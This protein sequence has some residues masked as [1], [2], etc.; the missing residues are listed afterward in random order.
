MFFGQILHSLP[1]KFSATMTSRQ[2]ILSTSTYYK[3]ASVHAALD[4][5][6][7]TFLPLYQ[8]MPTT[9]FSLPFNLLSFT[10]THLPCVK[11]AQL[12]QARSRSK[13]FVLSLKH[14]HTVLSLFRVHLKVINRSTAAVN[15]HTY[16]SASSAAKILQ[17]FLQ[18]SPCNGQ[19][20]QALM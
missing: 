15:S 5:A 13:P 17:C 2:F 12:N 14:T 7:R 1:L 19:W 16:G 10:L 20:C 6:Q 9:H 4:E 8:H 18:G 11:P 3:L